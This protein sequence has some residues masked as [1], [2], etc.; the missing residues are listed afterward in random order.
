MTAKYCIEIDKVNLNSL[1]SI[2]IKS[3][4]DSSAEYYRYRSLEWDVVEPIVPI[5]NGLN[6][7]HNY[8]WNNNAIND[9]K[10]LCKNEIKPIVIV[11]G[12]P[13]WTRSIHKCGPLNPDVDRINYIHFANMLKGAMEQLP[14]VHYWEIW[15]EEDAIFTDELTGS[16]YGS[17]C[18]QNDPIEYSGG[19]FGKFMAIVYPIIHI[20]FPK[21][22]IIFG[23]MNGYGIGVPMDDTGTWSSTLSRNTSGSKFF[24]SAILGA[25][26]ILG[27]GVK[28]FDIMG[29]HCYMG[30][31][32]TSNFSTNAEWIYDSVHA[33]LV[34]YGFDNI[35]IWYT[36]VGL[37]Y[38]NRTGEDYLS[39]N[40]QK[41][42]FVNNMWYWT[43]SKPLVEL[44]SYYC[45]GKT[46]FHQV[47]LD[48]DA[49][50]R[51]TGLANK[52]QTL[53]APYY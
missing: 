23:S 2:Q 12:C 42:R 32:P 44:M 25:R 19:L 30:S 33:D 3:I 39:L 51:Y 21:N 1:T 53:V 8:N 20:A 38:M 7:I 49:L 22:K 28:F 43:N 10:I 52:T 6:W 45:L 11:K 24:R 31:Y 46:G 50:M 27:N 26:T 34:E 40:Y 15:N 16:Y 18:R 41:K 48:G 35:S 13:S 9:L 36:E 29:I 47:Q 14:D 5:K 37:G 4:I 17:W